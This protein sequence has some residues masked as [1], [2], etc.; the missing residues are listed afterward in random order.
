MRSFNVLFIFLLIF[1][2]ANCSP[3]KFT[4]INPDSKAQA[5]TEP[6][7]DSSQPIKAIECG[8][9]SI[10]MPIK[11]LF[12]IDTSGSNS[13]SYGASNGVCDGRSGCVPATDP[14]KNF[15]AGSISTFFNKY[16]NRTNFSWGFETFSKRE[17]QSYIGS[18][19]SEIFGRAQAM[20][21]A[22]NSFSKEID[23][24]KTPYLE[25]LKNIRTAISSD[26]DLHS[27]A[28][29]PTLYYVIFMSDGYPTDSTASEINKEI[30]NIVALD[31]TRISLSTVYYSTLNDPHASAILQTMAERGGGQFI[32]FDI[33]SDETLSVQDL[34][35]L[36]TTTCQ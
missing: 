28:P 11:V 2:F 4:K 16:K 25:A 22:L 24:G 33:N 9:D 18:N 6:T 30:E 1:V 35:K 3:V 26:P 29:Y 12:V 21:A 34:V 19:T 17:V 14:Q 10:E 20:E 8:Q 23:R 27:M 5:F 13:I 15:R 7:Q 32:N 31:R 36:P